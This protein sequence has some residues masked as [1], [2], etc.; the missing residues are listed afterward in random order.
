MQSVAISKVAEISFVPNGVAAVPVPVGD[1]IF[2]VRAPRG[3]AGHIIDC[4]S[5]LFANHRRWSECVT[6]NKKDQVAFISYLLENYGD[7]AG[8]IV[9][10]GNY[11]QRMSRGARLTDRMVTNAVTLAR[12]LRELHASS[13]IAAQILA[14]GSLAC[15]R[16][17][18][19]FPL[20]QTDLAA[21]SQAITSKLANTPQTSSVAATAQSA[22]QYSARASARAHSSNGEIFRS[23]ANES[24][25]SGDREAALCFYAAST[26][27]FEK[28]VPLFIS[29]AQ[30][31]EAS[32]RHDEAAYDYCEAAGTMELLGK[33]DE[34]VGV[35][36]SAA[37][38]YERLAQELD[39]AGNHKA[40]QEARVN[41]EILSCA[42]DSENE[43]ICRM[44]HLCLA[45]SSWTSSI[46]LFSGFVD[47]QQFYA[48]NQV[49][50]QTASLVG[51]RLSTF[52]VNAEGL[53]RLK[54]TIRQIKESRAEIGDP[55]A[56]GLTVLDSVRALQVGEDC[57]MSGGWFNAAQQYGHEMTYRVQR[58]DENKYSVY[59][60]DA[61]YG[62]QGIRKRLFSN[63]WR[64]TPCLF[65]YE[66]GTQVD[67]CSVINKLRILLKPDPAAPVR[68]IRD[69][70]LCFK[71]CSMT[72]M[73]QR[74]QGYRITSQSGR[75]C[76]IKSVNC[77][78]SD[79]L[80]YALYKRYNLE[81]RLLAI[82]T[83]MLRH[84]HQLRHPINAALA[85][86]L[87]DAANN[88]LR[89]LENTRA[90]RLD[91]GKRV[92]SDQQYRLA[93]GIVGG[94]REEIENSNAY[95]AAQSNTRPSLELECRII[96]ET[97]RVF[98]KRHRL[99]Q[100]ANYR[101]P[102]EVTSAY[103]DLRRNGVNAQQ[104]ASNV[105]NWY[106]NNVIPLPGQTAS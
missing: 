54:K 73:R 40:A 75:N 104:A 102:D 103:R 89:I 44:V 9:Y 53:D 67:L 106:C 65:A 78:L 83:F 49:Y 80:G 86:F 101:T 38:A 93:R 8:S 6:E 55:Q 95:A 64:V 63:A 12:R 87:R 4:F 30:M 59:V 92:I 45:K 7:V 81:A 85:V 22:G 42:T 21:I 58:D 2:R 15:K 84:R 66:G 97:Y 10:A 36:G 19:A 3:F 37:H 34:A 43:L 100:R 74:Q 27:E 82:R 25:A 29:A 26:S 79:Y 77:L 61:L 60:Y 17:Q 14:P 90:R 48:R 69:V 28:A 35:R 20:S 41:Q 24:N 32:G 76:L 39:S 68:S 51:K 23:I 16:L 47:G 70:E 33:H 13:D 71:G 31:H 57:V 52:I 94:I 50:G 72:R 99:D 1:T 5:G 98:V 11:Y 18:K 56:D 46:P 62:M 105:W 88:F 96:D 91:G